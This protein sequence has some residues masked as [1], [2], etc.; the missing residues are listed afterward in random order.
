MEPS[1]DDNNFYAQTRKRVHTWPTVPQYSF[2]VQSSPY[3]SP[4]CSAYPSVSSLNQ[5]P[6][7]SISL[8][9][10]PPHVSLP[11][12]SQ[13]YYLPPQYSM[14]NILNGYN[15]INYH[16]NSVQTD[17]FNGNSINLTNLSSPALSTSS[18]D[19]S[20][21]ADS[22]LDQP[23][24][25]SAT[26]PP[27]LPPAPVDATGKVK[28]KRIR[29][30]DPN[31][32]VQK[33]PNAWGEESYSDLILKALESSPTGRMKLNE[34]Y[35]WFIDNVKYFGERCGSEEAAG[36]KVHTQISVLLFFREI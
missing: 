17:A 27:S 3:E 5:G 36:W 11:Q 6:L 31:Q 24:S 4:L 15:L 26:T 14:N 8:F 13:P 19:T 2:S 23:G 22:T 25:S 34:I 18:Q 9:C 30:K 12:T 28:R 21:P 16:Q 7:P 35:Q 29:K 20:T 1:I 33:K 10:G 32:I